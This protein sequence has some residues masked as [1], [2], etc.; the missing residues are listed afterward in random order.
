[1][2]KTLVAKYLSRWCYLKSVIMVLK[3]AEKKI[4]KDSEDRFNLVSLTSYKE[5]NPAQ[6]YVRSPTNL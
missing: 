2:L 4:F 1:M 6:I 5:D 3:Q